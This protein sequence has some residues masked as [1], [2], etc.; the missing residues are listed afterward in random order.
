MYIVASTAR[1]YNAKYELV[2]WKSSF[3]IDLLFPI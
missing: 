1:E 3:A 2:E